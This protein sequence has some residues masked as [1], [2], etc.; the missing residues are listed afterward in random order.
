LSNQSWEM[1]VPGSVLTAGINLGLL[2]DGDTVQGSVTPAVFAS[3]TQQGTQTGSPVNVAIG[4][5]SVDPATLQANDA[6]AKFGV[7][8]MTWTAVGGDVSFSLAQT[9]ALVTIGPLKI[10]FTCSPDANAAG[11]DT[12]HVLGKTD[13]PPAGKGGSTTTSTVPPTVVEGEQLARTGYSPLF[14]LVLGLTILD[15]GYLFWSAAQPPPDRRR[16]IG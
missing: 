8:D 10:T 9:S 13:I 15:L 11:F 12:V 14:F 2:N 3:N 4:P 6:S 16:L 7:A 1:D 5:I